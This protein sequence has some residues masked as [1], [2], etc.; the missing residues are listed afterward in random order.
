MRKIIFRGFSRVENKWLY[1]DPS[2]CLYPLI[3]SV[4]LKTG[5]KD[6]EGREIFEGD[7]LAFEI[8]RGKNSRGCVEYSD[9]KAQYVVPFQQRKYER[10]LSWICSL[11]KPVVIGNV[12]ENPDLLEQEQPN[13]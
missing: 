5:L 8:L 3:E 2:Q 10:S 13:A 4:G 6:S 12:Y 9:E 7:I 1:G 11:G